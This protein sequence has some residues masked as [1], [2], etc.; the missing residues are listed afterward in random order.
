M[1]FISMG[2][3]VSNKHLQVKIKF[4]TDT[5]VVYFVFV[6]ISFMNLYMV[7]YFMK[8][9]S[10]IFCN[11]MAFSSMN[12][13]VKMQVGWLNKL[14]L[15]H[16]TIKPSFPHTFLY[17]FL[18]FFLIIIRNLPHRIAKFWLYFK[19]FNSTGS[20]TIFL[21]CWGWSFFLLFTVI[22]KYH[23]LKSSISF[24]LLKSM[25]INV[26][27]LFHV[28]SSFSLIATNFIF[29]FFAS[30][31]QLY[32]SQQHCISNIIKYIII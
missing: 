10:R 23:A 32:Y 31:F 25:S 29:I 1:L 20:L 30:S 16:I 17:H 18:F 15:T 28:H 13:R 5:V 6:M 12:T 26:Y 11:S 3:T 2:T 21:W 24:M 7:S 27:N 22:C 9:V 19:Q 14:A 4:S 8:I